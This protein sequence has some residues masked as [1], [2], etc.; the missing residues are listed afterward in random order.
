MLNRARTLPFGS[1]GE[2]F[3]RAETGGLHRARTYALPT[4]MKEIA[5]HALAKTV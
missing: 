2:W 5:A 1:R 4:V 3:F